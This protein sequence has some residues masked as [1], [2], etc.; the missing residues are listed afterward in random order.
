M[1]SMKNGFSLVVSLPSLISFISKHTAKTTHPKLNEIIPL[2]AA[3]YTGVGAI[4]F[5]WGGKYSAWL[6]SQGK[7]T[8]FV[9]G[10]PSLLDAADLNT[11]SVPGLIVTAKKDPIF[12]ESLRKKAREQAKVQVVEYEDVVHGFCI[13]GREDEE[14]VVKARQDAMGRFSTF[15]KEHL[16]GSPLKDKE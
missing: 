4:G 13:R 5:C 7:I 6:A 12:S 2:L 9:A 10:H 15:F 8:C 14:V 1:E 3:Q 11:G 16:V